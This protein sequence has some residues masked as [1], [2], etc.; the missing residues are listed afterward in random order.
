MQQQGTAHPRHD[1]NLEKGEGHE[2]GGQLAA[3]PFCETGTASTAHAVS[4][5]RCHVCPPRPFD[6]EIVSRSAGGINPVSAQKTTNAGEKSG[7]ALRFL[8]PP[9]GK[10]LFQHLGGAAGKAVAA[11][12]GAT[13]RQRLALHLFHRRDLAA[14][15]GAASHGGLFAQLARLAKAERQAANNASWKDLVEAERNRRLSTI[16]ADSEAIEQRVVAEEKAK[17][18]EQQGAT[19][20]Q[21]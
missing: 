9:L 3:H 20:P 7:F 11:D 19:A 6:E 1:E 17:A 18:A 10:P 13:A 8:H 12:G 16:D 21:D 2:R 4:K 14:P 15:A 5:D